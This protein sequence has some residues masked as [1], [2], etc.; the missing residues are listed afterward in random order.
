MGRLKKYPDELIARGVR[1]ALE[2]ER[3]IA[4]IAADL[5]MSSETLSYDYTQ[6]LADHGVL[7][8]CGSVGDAYDNVL[9]ESFIDTIKTELIRD[10]IW[11][12]QSQLELAIVA[13]IGWYNHDRLHE[14]LGDVP[15]AE[16]EALALTE[17]L[18]D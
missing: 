9:A 17:T 7:A 18:R 10:G 11:R 6:V 14:A 12:T 15:P 13:Y 1:L 3:P 2:S 4:Q 8:S 5:G 16:Y